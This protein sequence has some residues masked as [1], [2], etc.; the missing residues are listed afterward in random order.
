MALERLVYSLNDEGGQPCDDVLEV[1]ILTS[2]VGAR[3]DHWPWW[4]PS[5]RYGVVDGV[6]SGVESM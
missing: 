4:P 3:T 1:A 2:S 5:S 6:V